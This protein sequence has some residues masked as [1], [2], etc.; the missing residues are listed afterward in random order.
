M[1]QIF[2][3]FKNVVTKNYANFK[4]RADRREFWSFVLVM[5][6]INVIFSILT[7]ISGGV[8][9]LYWIFLI[10]Q[11]IVS[12]ALLLPSLAVGVRRMHDIGKGG[13]WIFINLL[14]IIG[15]LWFLILTI[16]PSEEGENRFDN[17]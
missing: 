13:G 7:N 16:K 5:I 15:S 9:A 4:G 2:E 6:I 10:L 8:K 17:K 11:I 14:P 3:I 12:L 1:K